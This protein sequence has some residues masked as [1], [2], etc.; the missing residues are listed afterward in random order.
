MPKTK[1]NGTVFYIKA[2][3]QKFNEPEK[4]AAQARHPMVTEGNHNII[5]H[6]LEN[7]NSTSFYTAVRNAKIVIS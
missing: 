5:C 6:C 1:V 2:Q 7:R 3:I 4:Q